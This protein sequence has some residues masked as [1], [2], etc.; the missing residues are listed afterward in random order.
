VP[1]NADYQDLETTMSGQTLASSLAESVNR[2]GTVEG[3]A[4]D[5]EFIDGDGRRWVYLVDVTLVSSTLPSDDE[6]VD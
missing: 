5:V 3:A 2:E 1:V 6:S 4:F